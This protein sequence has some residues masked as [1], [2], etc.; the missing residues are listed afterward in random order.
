MKTHCSSIYT[1]SISC[2]VAVETTRTAEGQLSSLVALN[3][4][5]ETS[6][7]PRGEDGEEGKSKDVGRTSGDREDREV[8]EKER[9]NEF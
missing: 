3:K 5:K 6:P 7:P 9:V 1:L 2:Q 4:E 8:R